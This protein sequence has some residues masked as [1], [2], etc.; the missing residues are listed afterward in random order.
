MLKWA[1]SPLWYSLLLGEWE[2]WPLLL[3]R[4]WHLCLLLRETTII[5][6]LCPGLDTP[7]VFF[8]E[9]S[10]NL[11]AWSQVSS[12][13]PCDYWSIYFNG[14]HMVSSTVFSMAAGNTI[15]ICNVD[16]TKFLG[17]TIGVSPTISQ[18]VAS[19]K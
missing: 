17:R 13:Q 9:V 3:T 14:H 5:V 4:G 18:S 7:P 15:N 2:V 12:W 6:V 8:T 16:C 10:C 1:L 19:A 11:L